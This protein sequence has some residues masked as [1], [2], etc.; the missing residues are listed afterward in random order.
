MVLIQ[1][2]FQDKH[3]PIRLTTPIQRFGQPVRVQPAKMI[4]ILAIHQPPV[5]LMV[6]ECKVLLS[7]CHEEVDF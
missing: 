7:E 1:Q 2:S 4:H 5:I 3:T 6:M